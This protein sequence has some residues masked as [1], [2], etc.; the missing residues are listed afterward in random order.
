MNLNPVPVRFTDGP[1][2][3]ASWLSGGPLWS[4]RLL[5][6]LAQAVGATA[7]R[8]EAFIAA[9]AIFGVFIGGRLGYMFFYQ[10]LVR[11]GGSAAGPSRSGKEAWPATVDSR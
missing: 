9:A 1:A 6:V 10:S 7:W 3:L 5:N 8:G 11:H 2:P 4:G